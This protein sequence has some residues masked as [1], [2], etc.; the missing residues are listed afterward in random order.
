VSLP[1]L[2]PVLARELTQRMRGRQAWAVLVLYLA[3]LALIL[4]LV[5]AA[6]DNPVFAGGPDAFSA[7]TAGRQIFH[8]LLFFMLG[9]VSFIVPG[10]T[11]GAIAGERERQTLVS[12]QVTLLRPR[13]IVLGKLAASV[14]FVVLL[15][16]ATL[17]LIGVSF[18]LGGVALR[19]VL[20]GV[21]MVVLTAVVLAC[22]A[23]ACSALFRRTQGATVTAYGL[24]ALLVIGTFVVYGAQSATRANRPGRPAPTVLALNP[25]VATADVVRGRS[26]SFDLASPFR[27]LQELLDEET[28]AADQGVGFGI[29]DGP[30]PPGVAVARAGPVTT[31]PPPGGGF[32][33]I[34]PVPAPPADFRGF[35]VEDRPATVLGLRFW[36]ASLLAFAALG[37]GALAVAVRRV[38][39]P[40]PGAAA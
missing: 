1:P 31:V 17:P 30:V 25:F 13:S 33:Q 40:Q 38:A 8:W 19:E 14:A 21:A 3:V 9:L 28:F 6:S 15:I 36:V 32:V 24:T 27:A 29:A 11:G 18:V 10:V 35:I 2:N 37:A 34:A 5:Y 16:L 7:A 12:L 20:A 22:L 26:E 39:V 4:R 23:L